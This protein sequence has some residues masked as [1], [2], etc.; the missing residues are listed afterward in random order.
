[1]TRPSLQAMRRNAFRALR[2]GRLDDAAEAVEALRA[3]D[4][5][6][7]QTRGLEL[8]LLLREGK[9]EE[10]SAL[11]EQLCVLFPRSSR[12]QYLAG[13]AAYKERDYARAERCFSESDALHPHWK[14]RRW[15][16]KT[17]SQGRRLGEAEAILREIS[18]DHPV[19]HRDLA[20]VHERR[21]EIEQAL[22]ALDACAEA[23]GQDESLRTSRE[24]LAARRLGASEL[25]DE[26]ET[27]EALG[28]ELGD[29]LVPEVFAALLSRAEEPKARELA[30]S[31]LDRLHPSKVVSM[32]WAARDNLAWD[33]A[34][35]LFL[36]A[37]SHIRANM[38]MLACLEKCARSSAR[39]AEVVEAYEEHAP[40]QP[41]LYGRARNLR[42][43]L[44]RSQH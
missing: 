19:C 11:A 22:A 4:P 43:E 9:V 13:R 23:F 44:E 30:L 5:M 26:V 32:G 20:W 6:S 33:L 24:R 36:H 27:L 37:F 14:A 39:L 31:R 1:M 18:R 2:E 3:E 41:S 8:E 12:V 35:D 29:E 42:R 38:K 17:L 34:T 28:E 21:G 15:L 16:G 10:A 40:A 25:I 7:L